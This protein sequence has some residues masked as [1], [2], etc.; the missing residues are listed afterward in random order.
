M[1]KKTSIQSMVGMGILTAIVVVLQFIGSAIHFG[2][3]SISLVL[4]PIIIG[5][6][7]YGWKAGAWLGFVFGIMVLITDASAFLGISVP[8]TIITCIMKGV[9]AGAAAGIIYKLLEKKNKTLAVITA[10]I[11]CPVVNTGVFLLGC[12]L[13]FLRTIESW[14]AAAGYENVGKYLVF[15]FVGVNFLVELAIN[16]ILSTAIVRILNIV[17]KPSESAAA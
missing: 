10:G 12:V 11:A 13:F 16:L 15:G 14:G 17:K 9:L 6:A 1:A 5:A 4:A 8:G 7:L 2:P 3:F